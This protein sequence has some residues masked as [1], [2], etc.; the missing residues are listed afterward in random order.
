M[1]FMHGLAQALDAHAQG[2]LPPPELEERRLQ[3]VVEWNA[4]KGQDHYPAANPG[5][6]TAQ[7]AGF[8]KG[9]GE[10][11]FHVSRVIQATVAEGPIA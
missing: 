10:I 11:W 9:A 2:R 7:A 3:G 4:H 5:E 1:G 6:I 8:A